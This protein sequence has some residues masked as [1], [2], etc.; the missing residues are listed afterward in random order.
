MVNFGLFHIHCFFREGIKEDYEKNG[1]YSIVNLLN[2]KQYIGQTR[3]GLATRILQH[4]GDLLKR[5]KRENR[6]LVNSFNH[7]GA[8]NFGCYILEYAPDNLTQLELIKWLNDAEV[9][10][11]RHFRNLLGDRMLYNQ[12]DG[13]DGINPTKEYREN[14]SNSLK[15]T[16]EN[17]V[18][19]QQAREITLKRYEDPAEHDKTSKALKKAYENP[20]LRQQAREITL[21]RFGDPKEHEKLSIAM[22]DAH[23]EHPEYRE[24][25]SKS[26]KKR[27]EDPKEHE[28]LS[29]IIS[30][31]YEDPKEHEKTSITIKKAFEDPIK[32]KKLSDR[33]IR[34]YARPGE[35]Q[36]ESERQKK[37]YKEK[38]ERREKQS[39]S[40]LK[41]YEDDENY[42]Y[43]CKWHKQSNKTNKERNEKIQYGLNCVLLPFLYWYPYFYKSSK[44][45]KLNIIATILKECH[46][47]NVSIVTYRT[48]QPF[49]HIIYEQVRKKKRKSDIP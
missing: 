40:H 5:N 24:Q 13:G 17:P 1:I 46:K 36:K 9:K 26:Q 12:N 38:P 29:A 20:I 37:S 49:V 32:R 39:K 8:D 27:F 42:A 10:W 22:I 31:R 34:R 28:K 44:N 4:Q 11:I 3:N 6:H 43:F 25:K 7:Y 47:R 15:K 16:Y 45:H 41:F 35:R 18:L 48:I 19:R 21:K 2:G 30:K 23:N 14:L 33:N